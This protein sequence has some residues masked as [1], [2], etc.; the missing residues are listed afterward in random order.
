MTKLCIIVSFSQARQGQLRGQ[1]NPSVTRGGSWE[2]F[3][4]F[5]SRERRLIALWLLSADSGKVLSSMGVNRCPLCLEKQRQIDDLTDENRRLKEALRRRGRREEDGFFGS[6]TPSSKKPIKANT[7]KKEIKA[8]GARPGHKGHG[9]KGHSEIPPDRILDVEE[10][11]ERCPECGGPLENKGWEERSVI[12]SPPQRAEP[13]LYRLGKRYCPRCRRG[14]TAPAPGVL[15]KSLYGNQLIANVIVMHYLYGLSLGRVSEYSGVGA[16]S[17]MTIFHRC[18]GLFE[19]APA[20]L[21]E[22]YRQAPVK[23]ADETGWRTDGK[24]GYVWL[25][26]TTRLSIFQFGK[27]RSAKIPQAVFGAEPLPGVL[28]VDRYNGYNKIRCEIQYCYA[29][30]LRDVQ[31]LEKEFPDS[32]EVSTFVA[33]VAPLMALAMG[34]RSQPLSDDQFFSEGSRVRSELKAAMDRPAR[35]QGIRRIQDIFRE[36]E[37]RLYHWAEDKAVPADNNLAERDLRPSVI[38]RKVSFGSV[39]DA[40]AKVR[41]TLTT[42]VTTLKK[43]GLDAAQGIKETLDAL[44]TDPH[45][46]AYRLLFSRA[47]PK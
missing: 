3:V 47:G 18:A 29:H 33:V 39:T 17:L 27:N 2:G 31:D 13:V 34:L 24:N 46:D 42:I 28:V 35:H 40:G 8:K 30:L 1:G 12:D 36:N 15:P 7:E 25:F 10:Q 4:R 37:G 45:Q 26:A 19:G 20:K 44:A 21:I 11:W 41:S 32:A 6:S 14:F 16:G 38:A 5:F 23:H 9:R 43:Q 22:E